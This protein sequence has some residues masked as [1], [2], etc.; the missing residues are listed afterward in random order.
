[1]PANVIALGSTLGYVRYSSATV[2]SSSDSP[3]FSWTNYVKL[4]AELR[5]YIFLT[6]RIAPYAGVYGSMSIFSDAI[7][8][9]IGLHFGISFWLPSRDVAFVKSVR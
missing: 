7:Y 8:Y 4:Q 9:R 2:S 6:D 3:D 1:M 5:D